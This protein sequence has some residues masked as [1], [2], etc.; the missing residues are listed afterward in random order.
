MCKIWGSPCVPYNAKY[1][2]IMAI[3]SRGAINILVFFRIQN[4]L[5]YIFFKIYN[6]WVN[7]CAICVWESQFCTRYS[8][9]LLIEKHLALAL[10]LIR[11]CI[12]CKQSMKGKLPCKS[13]C[14][15]SN[16]MKSVDFYCRF[17]ILSNYCYIPELN[18]RNKFQCGMWWYYNDIIAPWISTLLTLI[19][20]INEWI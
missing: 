6:F 10:N 16:V 2:R 3:A 15:Q 13:T 9:C 18:T 17:H 1:N 7:F 8:N 5:I 19:H 11:I 12:K 14:T 4:Y 20:C